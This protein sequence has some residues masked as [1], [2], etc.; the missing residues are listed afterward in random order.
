MKLASY[1]FEGRETFGLVVEGGLIDLGIRTNHSSLR[2]LIAGGLQQ[3]RALQAEPADYPADRVQW[4]P[5]IPDPVHLL[6]IGLNTRSHF[7]ETAELQK[8]VPGDYPSRPRIFFRSPLSVV[9]HECDILIPRVSE[10]LDWEGEIVA[11]IGKGGRYLSLEE[12]RNAILGFALG[13]DG[14]VRDFQ[15]HS[16][17]VTA[18]KNF[19]RSGSWGPWIV[20]AD[21]AR[22]GQGPCLTLS[23]NAR[24]RQELVLDD[25]IFGFGELVS[26]ISQFIPLQP[27]DA[28]FTGSPAGIGALGREWLRDGDL[29]EVTSSTLGTL[30]NRIR[31]E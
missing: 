27:G 19:Y 31:A 21:E 25:L 13:N 29:V 28:I 22:L 1:I 4:Q 8:R 2:S 30:R 16:N 5:P 3:A 26:Y 12:A 9:G 10:M 7:A 24:A 6:G 11:V 23:V 15:I 14:S 18:G 20:T 17:Q